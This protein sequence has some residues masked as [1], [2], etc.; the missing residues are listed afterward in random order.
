MACNSKDYILD[1]IIDR[2]SEVYEELAQPKQNA[3]KVKTKVMLAIHY[4]EQ[5]KK[6]K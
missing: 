1:Q 4:L 3:E 6:M 2:L 5:I